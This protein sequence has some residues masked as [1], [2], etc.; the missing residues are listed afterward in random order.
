MKT[1]H[2]KDEKRR[3]DIGIVQEREEVE[4]GEDGQVEGREKSLVA[5]VK[6]EQKS[7]LLSEGKGPKSGIKK[8]ER[9]WTVNQTY[10]W[11]QDVGQLSFKDQILLDLSLQEVI[12]EILM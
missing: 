10:D 1:V 5:V 6:L 2:Q 12:V 7:L 8:T 4:E 3:S 9:H 11:R